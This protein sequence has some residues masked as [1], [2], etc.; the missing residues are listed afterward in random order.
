MSFEF[1]EPILF[2]ELGFFFLNNFL[3]L[4]CAQMSLENWALKLFRSFM[5]TRLDESNNIHQWM[6]LQKNF[7][8]SH[9]TKSE[10]NDLFISL[11]WRT[12]VDTSHLDVLDFIFT[13]H[14]T[15]PIFYWFFC[16]FWGNFKSSMGS[17][18]NKV[19]S[20]SFSYQKKKKKH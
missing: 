18:W 20:N 10:I 6:Q 15:A 14:W 4:E 8:P 17:G 7:T 9:S 5:P 16:T 11:F 19:K 2:F 13:K 3:H 12:G 1:C